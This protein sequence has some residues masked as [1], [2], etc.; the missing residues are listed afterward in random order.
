MKLNEIHTGPVTWA[1]PDNAPGA[2][3]REGAARK[4]AAARQIV[5]NDAW[6][7]VAADL[8]GTTKRIKYDFNGDKRE[9]VQIT[10][11]HWDNGAARISYDNFSHKMALFIE[12]SPIPWGRAAGADDAK[13]IVLREAKKLGLKLS[14]S[15]MASSDGKT[16]DWINLAYSIDESE[17]DSVVRFVEFVLEYLNEF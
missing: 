9:F 11:L 5:S 1:D 15:D 6:E 8:E 7:E 12:N 4:A 17:V 3:E 14:G 13:A 2:I 10:G 16:V